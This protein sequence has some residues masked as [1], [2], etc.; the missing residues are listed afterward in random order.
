[1]EDKYIS[2][3]SAFKIDFKSECH[4]K[5]HTFSKASSPKTK[6]WFTTMI[7]EALHV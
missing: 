6:I 7:K 1:M 2:S 3:F 4:S 5:K